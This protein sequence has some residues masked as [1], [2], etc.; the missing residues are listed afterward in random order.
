MRMVKFQMKIT[1]SRFFKLLLKSE[2]SRGIYVGL[3]R[4]TCYQ[5]RN[6]KCS[7]IGP[8]SFSKEGRNEQEGDTSDLN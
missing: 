7:D 3:K 6:G 5:K 2:I 1:R 4:N 8:A